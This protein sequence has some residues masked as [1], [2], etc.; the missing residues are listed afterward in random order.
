MLCQSDLHKARGKKTHYQVI[1]TTCSQNKTHPRVSVSLM[2]YPRSFFYSDHRQANNTPRTSLTYCRFQRCTISKQSG[3]AHNQS[4]Y[5]SGVARWEIGSPSSV[6]LGDVKTK[7]D[8]TKP[9]STPPD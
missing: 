2:S 3:Q 1:F 9:K 4:S 5:S 8:S 6:R 7:P